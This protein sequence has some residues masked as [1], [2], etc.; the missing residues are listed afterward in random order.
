MGNIIAWIVL[1]LLAGAIARAIYPGRQA[2]GII[3]TMILGIIGALVGGFLHSLIGGS[4]VSG[5]L[6]FVSV[7][8]A[9]FGAIVTLFVYYAVT[10]KAT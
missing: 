7:V 6:N 2:L 10:K 5:G 9:V 3:G 4:G 1:G 8:V